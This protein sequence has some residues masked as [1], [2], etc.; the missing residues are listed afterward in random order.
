MKSIAEALEDCKTLSTSLRAELEPFL[1]PF[2]A[3]L[4]DAR[5]PSGPAPVRGRDV[6][7]PLRQASQSS[8]PCTGPAGQG[9]S[10]GQTL[11]QCHET[12]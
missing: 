4:P 2:A 11:L 6:G 12:A 3:V 10:V 8:N 5:L 1:A 9:S 7:R